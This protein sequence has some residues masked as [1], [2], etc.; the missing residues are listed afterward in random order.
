MSPG[1]DESLDFAKFRSLYQHLS[2]NPE[3]FE[4]ACF[5]RYFEVLRHT[6]SGSR[7]VI[8]DSD[9]LINDDARNIPSYIKEFDL[10]IVGS[11]GMCKGIVEEDV[12][13]HFSFWSHALLR[14]FVDYLIATYE[15]DIVRLER[16]FAMRKAAGNNRAAISDMTLLHM[17]IQDT[18]VPFLNSN[19]VIDG[20]YVDHNFSMA[21]TE[22][23]TFRLEVGFKAFRDT[24]RGIA[25][26][27]QEQLLIH[28][29]V[30]HLQGRAKI[31]AKNLYGGSHVRARCQLAALTMAKR[32]RQWIS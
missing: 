29:L 15:R 19:R 24:P 2:I 23:A 32:L 11:L 7:F 28:P 12:S 13:P 14:R 17:F 18:G 26:L 5:R 20:Q 1:A 31:M 21:E 22:N 3:S 4:L 9:L 6:T 25:F 30:I 27:T 10:G 8:A 16:T